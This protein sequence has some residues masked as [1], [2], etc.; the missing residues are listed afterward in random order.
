MPA[1][2]IASGKQPRVHAWASLG[3]TAP[4][5]RYTYARLDRVGR[6]VSGAGLCLCLCLCADGAN[7]AKS[8]CTTLSDCRFLDSFIIKS[9]IVHH[10]PINQHASLHIITERKHEPKRTLRS[11]PRPRQSILILATAVQAVSASDS[12]R[13]QRRWG[14]QL[15]EVEVVQGCGV[16][17]ALLGPRGV[18]SRDQRFG[19][20][21]ATQWLLQAAH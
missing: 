11:C 20:S 18:Y 5:S 16:G 2:A 12:A 19:A 4:Y 10:R 6:R 14:L 17:L 9:S 15:H 13:R 3:T 8:V 7:Q 1:F 21:Q